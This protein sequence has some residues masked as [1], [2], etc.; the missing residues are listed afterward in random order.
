[1][2]GMHCAYNFI[3][4]ILVRYITLLY[5]CLSKLSEQMF[6]SLILSRA[7]VT[8]LT[9]FQCNLPAINSVKLNEAPEKLAHN[10][11]RNE[12]SLFSRR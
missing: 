2:Y 9:R 5:A 3:H 1:M 7:F 4:T 6:T 12:L 8:T 11:L 10:R